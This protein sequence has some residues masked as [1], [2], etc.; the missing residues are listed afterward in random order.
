M[1]ELIDYSKLKYE[2]LNSMQVPTLEEYG[3]LVTK[4]KAEEVKN[5]AVNLIKLLYKMERW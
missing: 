2:K 1:K 5:A 3:K 4:E